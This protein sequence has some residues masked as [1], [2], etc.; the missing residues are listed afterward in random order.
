[1]FEQLKH[2]SSLFKKQIFVF[3]AIFCSIFSSKA[4]TAEPMSILFIGNSYT[5]MNNMPGIFEKIAIKA[6]K[7]VHVEKNTQSGASFRVHA[8]REDMYAAI[9]SRKWD[10]VIL[11]G[12]SREFTHRPEYIDT[13]T[14]PFL[15]QITDSIYKNNP[16]TNIMFY[17][18]WGYESGFSEDPAVDSFDKMADS[19]SRGYQYVADIFN[20]P[21]VPVGKVWKL[22]KAKS[23]IDL[24][25]PDRAHPSINGSFLIAT[26]FFEAI[27]NQSTEKVFTSTVKSENAA[28]IKRQ[29]HSFVSKNRDIYKLNE[30]R[31]D[32]KP[33][34]TAKGEYVLELTANYIC[35]QEYKW[36]FGDGNS[37]VKPI[38][39]HKYKKAGQY[40]VKLTV[41]DECG[42][43]YHERIIQYEKPEMPSEKSP[44]KPKYNIKNNKKI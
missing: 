9:N 40:K 4:A 20:V 1:M 8:G 26:T 22:V 29:V 34:I 18:T 36:D 35:A 15:M 12:F 42:T 37:S 17:M 2:Y 13:A 33:Y 30:N 16:C 24:Y 44:T 25:A 43:R 11:Q 3:M 27:F 32:L 14:M 6:G 19:I 23:S 31:F 38:T 10:Y 21:I 41:V 7:N 39:I 5:H 28:V